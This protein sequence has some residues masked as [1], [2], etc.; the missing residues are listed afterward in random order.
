MVEANMKTLIAIAILALA[1]SGC[2]TIFQSGPDHV[3]VTSSPSGAKVFLDGKEVGVTPIEVSIE[4]DAEGVIRIEKDGYNPYTK[5][6]DKKIN[7]WLI[8]DVIYIIPAGVDLITHNQ[9][10]YPTKPVTVDL[11]EKAPAI[12]DSRK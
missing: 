5:D 12:S 10:H 7:W 8:A 4:R 11:S 6:L 1:T 2:A 9:G 3:P